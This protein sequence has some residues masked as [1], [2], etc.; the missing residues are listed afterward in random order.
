MNHSLQNK[1]KDVKQVKWSKCGQYVNIKTLNN[2]ASL[3]IGQN[4]YKV[5]RK[6]LM[7]IFNMV[8]STITNQANNVTKTPR[9]TIKW[10]KSIYSGNISVDF[11]G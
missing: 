11:K 4:Y 9:G 7:V 3:F 10:I 1:I 8:L 2:I 5:R 6:T